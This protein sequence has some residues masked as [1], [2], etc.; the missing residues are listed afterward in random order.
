MQNTNLQ[1]ECCL[2]IN[3]KNLGDFIIKVFF[4]LHS[5]TDQF[6]GKLAEVSCT[7][8]QSRGEGMHM[9]HFI[10]MHTKLL[11]TLIGASKCSGERKVLSKLADR[12]TDN[13]I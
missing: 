3:E 5:F 4:Y 9:L 6:A 1:F 13:V 8:L 11:G 10:R 7:G 2:N 12:V